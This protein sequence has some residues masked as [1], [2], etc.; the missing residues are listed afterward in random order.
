M[1]LLILEVDTSVEPMM[2]IPVSL[3][4]W[5]VIHTKFS[6]HVIL[7]RTTDGGRGSYT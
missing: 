3:F 6:P 5:F 7:M 4:I 2:I 1:Y